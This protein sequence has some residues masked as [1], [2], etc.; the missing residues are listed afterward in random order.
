MPRLHLVTLSPCHLESRQSMDHEI[1]YA[2]VS[3]LAQAIRTQAHFCG[4]AGIKPT[5]GRAAA[6]GSR[7][8]AGAPNTTECICTPLVILKSILL[9]PMLPAV[10]WQSSSFSA[11]A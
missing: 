7:L 4:I 3:T 5:L 6:S 9:L 1:I 11:G 10:P 8:R 2:P